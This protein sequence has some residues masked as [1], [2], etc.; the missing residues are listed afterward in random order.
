MI[1]MQWDANDSD[2]LLINA[3]PPLRSWQEVLDAVNRVDMLGKAR[4]TP[5]FVIAQAGRLSPPPGNEVRPVFEAISNL[6]DNLIFY[7][8]T[9]MRFTSMLPQSGLPGAL[10][11]RVHAAS[12]V[13]D[14]RRQI[15]AYR[16]EHGLSAP[17][18]PNAAAHQES[19]QN[20]TDD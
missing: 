16:T 13:D 4:N 12:S 10:I 14:A 15:A 18:R 17:D 8:V 9:D 2:I 11:Q 5:V 20:D 6:S 1:D 19:Y 3:A 7:V